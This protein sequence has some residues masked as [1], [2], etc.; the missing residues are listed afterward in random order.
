MLGQSA[1]PPAHALGAHA[2]K[3]GMNFAVGGSGVF[4]V[5]QEKPTLGMQV[6]SFL[7]RV[8][9]GSIKRKLLARRSVALV[10]VSVLA[11]AASA[12]SRL[13]SRR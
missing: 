1:A 9:A 7:S 4:K 6:D 5:P 13:W 11:R 8:Q 10:A 2:G 3:A 12:K